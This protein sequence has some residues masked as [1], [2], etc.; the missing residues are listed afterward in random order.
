MNSF[1]M[2]AAAVF[3]AGASLPAASMARDMPV[4]MTDQEMAVSRGG[5]VVAGME[6]RIGAELRTFIGGELVMKTVVNWDQDAR[7]TESWAAPSLVAVEPGS[8][9]KTLLSGGSISASLD[10]QKVY[11]A[12][13]GRTALLQSSDGKIQNM[14]FNTANGIDLRQE[15]DVSLAL[16]GYKQ[17]HE[18]MAPGILMTGLGDALALSALTASRP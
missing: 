9:A 17:F 10:G 16:S 4:I 12:N 13:E 7:M 14:V 8:L 1:Q 3:V 2:V 11:L 5:F 18:A 6:I 15:A